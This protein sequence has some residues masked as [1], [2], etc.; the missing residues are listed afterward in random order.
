MNMKAPVTATRTAPWLAPRLWLAFG[1]LA[2]G[3]LIA[4][5]PAAAQERRARPGFG[6]GAPGDRRT[7]RAVPRRPR[8][9]CSPGVDLSVASR[10]SGK[11][12]GGP[13]KRLDLAAERGVGR[14]DRRAAELSRGRRYAQR[15]SRLDLRSRHGRA[16]SARRRAERDPEFSRR[17]VRRRQ[18]TQRRAPDRRERRRH[19]RDQ[20]RGPEGHLHPVL[21][22]GA[23]RR[24]S[25]GAGLLLLPA[26]L[27][28]LLLPVS[29]ALQLQHGVLLGREHAGSRSA[30]TRTTCTPTTR[31][32]TA[33]RTTVAAITTRFT[34]ATCT[35]ITTI[36]IRTTSGSR[37]YGY[38]GRPVVRGSEGRV[39]A[40]DR[41]PRH[42]AVNSNAAATRT[43]EKARCIAPPKTRGRQPRA[44]PMRR[45]KGAAA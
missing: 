2:V 3:A 40:A 8:R 1:V 36:A 45:S 16:E 38:G 9:H 14:L 7:D 41:A 39:Y 27:P 34:C 44:S 35:S 33:I 5:R 17:G 4:L 43:R 31:S 37:R 32:I 11:I 18:P 24:L 22:A 42:G 12:F 10:S 29:R 26:A 25:A 13:E 30:G 15:R 6:R 28:G 21:R 23:R 20:A 19:D